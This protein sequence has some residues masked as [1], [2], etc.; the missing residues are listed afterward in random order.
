MSEIK[1]VKNNTSKATI[2]ASRMIEDIIGCKW[3]LMVL[4]TICSGI[5][6]PGAIERSIE[7]ITTKVLNERLRKLIRYKII[8]RQVYPETPPKVEYQLTEFGKKFSKILADIDELDD[9]IEQN[10]SS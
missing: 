7:G 10:L 1:L 6:R 5:C 3:S 2:P 9:F 8:D 4:Q